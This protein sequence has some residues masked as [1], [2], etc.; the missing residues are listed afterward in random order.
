MWIDESRR[1]LL[2][3]SGYIIGFKKGFLLSVWK[4]WDFDEYAYSSGFSDIEK[5]GTDY[6]SLLRI[7]FSFYSYHVFIILQTFYYFSSVDVR[8]LAKPVSLS[9]F[10]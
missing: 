10:W 8:F 1:I 4:T 9:T 3:S 5:K 7:P 6:R 2:V